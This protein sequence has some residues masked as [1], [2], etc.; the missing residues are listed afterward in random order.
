MI[1]ILLVDDD[2]MSLRSLGDFLT[3]AG[4]AVD[5]LQCP[6]TALAVTQVRTYDLIVSDYQ[7]PEMNGIDI[8]RKVKTEQPSIKSIL[9]T[10]YF[11]KATVDAA[12]A[13][14]IDRF[15]SKPIRIKEMIS[16]IHK[17]TRKT[18]VDSTHN[19]INEEKRT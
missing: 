13:A 8:I 2:R 15:F 3:T 18:G 11:T 9:Y 4:F 12:R 16:A 19:T 17:L 6:Q 7:L 14:G 5:A 1:R 10:G